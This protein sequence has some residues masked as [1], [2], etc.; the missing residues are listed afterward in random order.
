MRERER[1]RI[2]TSPA[3]STLITMELIIRN[4]N[5]MTKLLAIL[6]WGKPVCWKVINE[7]HTSQHFFGPFFFLIWSWGFR[8]VYSWTKSITT[9]TYIVIKELAF[10]TKVLSHANS[11]FSTIL[12]DLIWFLK[13]EYISINIDNLLYN[14]F[15]FWISK[16][17]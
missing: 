3:Y 8:G 16:S 10:S 2:E 11:T 1:E 15:S 7:K 14:V 13:I 4:L 6:V 5:D 12:L 17:W 9:E